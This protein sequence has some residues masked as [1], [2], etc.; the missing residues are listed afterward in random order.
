MIVTTETATVYRYGGRRYFSKDAA[1]RSAARDVLR[2][3]YCD[4]EPASVVVAER[5]RDG[6]DNG[7]YPPPCPLHCE[8]NAG[9]YARRLARLYKW[10]KRRDR[11]TL[12]A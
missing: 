7:Y 1:Y 9:W 5:W 8:E 6:F 2:A 12:S 3:K 10:L 4:C 11:I